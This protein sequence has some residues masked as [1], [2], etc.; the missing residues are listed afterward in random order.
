MGADVEVVRFA[1]LHAGHEECFQFWVHGRPPKAGG[2]DLSPVEVALELEQVIHFFLHPLCPACEAAHPY[3]DG[4]S[5]P[6]LYF[7][8]FQ[9]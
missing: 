5:L 2:P 1:L 6:D 7:P 9:R 3:G 8:R 4:P